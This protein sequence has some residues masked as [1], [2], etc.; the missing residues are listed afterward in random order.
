MDEEEDDD[1]D[2]DDDD[3]AEDETIEEKTRKKQSE[4]K[5]KEKKGI[6]YPRMFF[7]LMDSEMVAGK[8]GSWD[9]GMRGRGDA[10]THE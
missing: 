7:L 6:E 5:R 1:D 9:A 4:A 8:L 2:D 10:G 3:D